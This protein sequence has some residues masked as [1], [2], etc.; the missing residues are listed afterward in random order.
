MTKYLMAVVQ[1]D[2]QDN[3]DNN[4]A[5]VASYVEEA[6]HAGARMIA[7]PEGMNYVG[8]DSVGHAE[9]VPGGRTFCFMSALAKKYK[10][11]L[12]CGSIY[13]KNNKDHRPYNC[14]MII[15]PDGELVAKYHKMHP[16]DVVIANGPTNKESDRICPGDEIVTVP[17]DEVGCLGL[18]ICYDIRFP[19][20]YRIMVL[21]GAQVL[22]VPADFTM[23][24]GK[25]HWETLLRSRAI[26]NEC[27]VVAPAQIGN[28]PKFKAYG[29][30][31][32]IDPWGTVIARAPNHA[33]LIMAEINLDYEN[34][35]RHQTY[36]LANRRSDV[37][38][39]KYNK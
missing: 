14:S 8:L 39:L 12:H 4:L 25:D 33:D 6:A 24:T 34:D 29:N 19:E 30:A 22:F 5:A 13:E 20:L 38:A 1:M 37:Y 16:F 23:I 3:V 32:I 26:E 17:T 28:K 7:F 18:S 15:N 35:V 11:W 27:Y 31:M 9:E 21:N 2:S 36:A 10:M